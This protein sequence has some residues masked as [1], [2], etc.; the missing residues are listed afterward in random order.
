MFQIK[1]ERTHTHKT[2][3]TLAGTQTNI[4]LSSLRKVR[5]KREV[6]YQLRSNFR[7]LDLGKVC[8]SRVP[9]VAT[10]GTFGISSLWRSLLSGGRYFRGTKIV[11]K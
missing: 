5:K 9:I 2:T 1:N 3:P 11:Y 8:Y 10:L 6:G 7:N 4:Y